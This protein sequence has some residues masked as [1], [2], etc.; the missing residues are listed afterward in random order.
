MAADVDFRKQWVQQ[1]ARAQSAASRCGWSHGKQ[2][3]ASLRSALAKAQEAHQVLTLCGGPDPEDLKAARDRS[4]LDGW[5]SA[6]LVQRLSEAGMQQEAEQLA[7]L[8]SPLDPEHRGIPQA[9]AGAARDST[10]TLEQLGSLV[11]DCT[12]TARARLHAAWWMATL[13][14]V[15]VGHARLLELLDAA[16][17]AGD[18]LGSELAMRALRAHLE[19]RRTASAWPDSRNL[20]TLWAIERDAPLTEPE[21]ARASWFPDQG[22]GAGAM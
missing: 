20:P 21:E 5:K 16:M 12:R 2:G 11:D 8:A 22:Y 10:L 4:G 14:H 17:S 6:R 13:A 15:E 9:V 7:Q 3:Q 1:L 19:H 18:W